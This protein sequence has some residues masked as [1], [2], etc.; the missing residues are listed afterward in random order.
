MRREWCSELHTVKGRR[1]RCV[2]L[3]GKSK[4]SLRCILLTRGTQS[5]GI[6]IPT[7]AWSR[8]VLQSLNS[9]S[10]PDWVVRVSNGVTLVSGEF[11]WVWDNVLG[12]GGLILIV[13]EKTSAILLSGSFVRVW[14][15]GVRSS[16]NRR[17]VVRLLREPARFT[18]C[19]LRVLS[20]FTHR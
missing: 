5:F 19:L 16:L 9:V 13:N 6:A 18:E 12:G 14:M 17:I 1:I 3:I 11:F 20:P 2:K 10:K 8:R 15:N 7:Q 4:A